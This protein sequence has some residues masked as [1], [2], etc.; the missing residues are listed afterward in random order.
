M[1]V[2]TKREKELSSKKPVFAYWG[3]SSE[4]VLFVAH[5]DPFVY[6]LSFF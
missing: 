1:C 2:Y 5:T 6:I 4:N 3:T